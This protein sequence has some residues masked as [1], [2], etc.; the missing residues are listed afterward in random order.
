M[1]TWWNNLMDSSNNVPWVRRA[2][3]ELKCWT[4]KQL[5]PKI[6]VRRKTLLL[7]ADYKVSWTIDPSLLSANSIVYSCGVGQDI[8]FDCQLIDHFGVSVHAFDPTPQCI[9]WIA[10]QEC[11]RGFHFHPFGIA[12]EDGTIELHA[13]ANIDDDISHSAVR[14]SEAESVSV[15]VRR[16]KSIMDELGHDRIDLLKMDIEGCEYQVLES[17]LEDRLTVKQ[18]LVEFHHRWPEIGMQRTVQCLAL[19]REH[20]FQVF[21]VSGLWD[22]YSLIRE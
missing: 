12:A 21:A 4:G 22:E 20:G 9:A 18:L 5:R 1:A 19:L 8:S 10:E 7:G 13:P 17:L 14:S 6:D 15:P 11:P 2:K 16:I 3:L